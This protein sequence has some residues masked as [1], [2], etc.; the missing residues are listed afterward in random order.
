MSA[1]S[2]QKFWFRILILSGSPRMA[3][4]VRFTSSQEGATEK[5]ISLDNKSE[6]YLKYGPLLGGMPSS[7]TTGIHGEMYGG[8]SAQRLGYPS[9]SRRWSEGYPTGVVMRLI[10]GP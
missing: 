6:D 10:T 2:I 3:L 5:E 8:S 4:L 9:L 7:E 1:G